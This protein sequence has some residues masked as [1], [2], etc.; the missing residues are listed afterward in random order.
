M[1]ATNYLSLFVK[2][3]YMTDMLYD[4]YIIYCLVKDIII[5]IWIYTT[6]KFEFRTVVFLYKTYVVH[7]LNNRTILSE[8]LR[9]V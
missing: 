1:F 5:Y 4:K 6:E 7:I 2:K 3:N 8:I 9:F